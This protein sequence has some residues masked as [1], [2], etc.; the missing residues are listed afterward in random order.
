MIFFL[1][2]SL[3]AAC[4]AGRGAEYGVEQDSPYRKDSNRVELNIYPNP[5]E[6]GRITI[7]MS[8]GKIAEI[9]LVNIAGKEII[10]QKME[11]GISKYQLALE[12]VPNGIY[13]I[14]VQSPEDKIFVKKLIVSGR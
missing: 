9:K 11:S 5:T 2:I 6:T 10:S 13:F 12:N 1:F 4:F 14:R 3:S 8:S 7:E